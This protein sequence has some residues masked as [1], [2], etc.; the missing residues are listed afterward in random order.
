MSSKIFYFIDFSC[1]ASFWPLAVFLSLLIF[2]QGISAAPLPSSQDCSW[3]AQGTNR[4][5][6]GTN[7]QSGKMG[8]NGA[9][10]ANSDNL[11]IFADGTPLTLNLAGKNG[12]DGKPGEMRSRLIVGINPVMSGYGSGSSRWGKW[13]K[14]R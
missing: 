13:G 2:P 7:G 11:T 8:E 6:F 4:Q 3:L 9:N 10:G 5:S 1:Y 12:E 14:W